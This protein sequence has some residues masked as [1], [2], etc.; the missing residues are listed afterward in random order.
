MNLPPDI[1]SKTQ[2]SINDIFKDIFRSSECAKSILG[3]SFQTA[4]TEI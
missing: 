2:S 3:S 1:K 4:I